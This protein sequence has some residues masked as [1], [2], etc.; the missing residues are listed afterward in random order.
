MPFERPD[1]TNAATAGRSK[2]PNWHFWVRRIV[3]GFNALVF[4]FFLIGW[5]V[6]HVDA[7]MMNAGVVARRAADN[8]V[9]GIVFD[10][11]Q[12]QISV[13]HME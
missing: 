7:E 8:A 5:D 3:K 13:G 6:R 11:H 4:E 9:C 10:Q 12:I 1:L 2:F